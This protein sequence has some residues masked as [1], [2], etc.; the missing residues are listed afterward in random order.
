[1]AKNNQNNKNEITVKT[2]TKIGI[3][4]INSFSI[5][6]PLMCYTV[7]PLTTDLNFKIL[8]GTEQIINPKAVVYII[9]TAIISIGLVIVSC[10]ISVKDH[11]ILSKKAYND[12]RNKLKNAEADNLAFKSL[13]ESFNTICDNKAHTLNAVLKETSIQNND[14]KGTIITEPQ[15]QLF[16]IFSEHMRKHLMFIMD[17]NSSKLDCVSVS[18]AYK[19]HNSE[20][21]WLEGCE[22]ASD[23]NAQQLAKNSKSAF[24]NLLKA[25]DRFIFYNSKYEEYKKGKYYS[26]NI[27][28]DND[29]SLVGHRI[30]IGKAEKPYAQVVVFFST[31]ENLL[32]VPSKN[33]KAIV[34]IKNKLNTW[35]FTSFDKRIRI[36]LSLFF[37]NIF[38]N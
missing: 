2:A 31:S 22:P 25:S 18:V 8:N 38:P 1:M 7:I 3:I 12:L 26:K 13:Y 5:L 4:I 32:F 9:I 6:F 37:L 14:Y 23:F 20:W 27:E 35:L 28:K 11:H 36:E 19:I 30:I 24:Y 16:R 34:D 17:I 15:D 10:Y 29:G 21:L 33:K